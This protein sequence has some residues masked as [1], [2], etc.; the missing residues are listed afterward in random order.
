M[1]QVFENFAAMLRARLDARV[2][3]TEDSI[4]YT[5]YVAA[6]MYAGVRPTE[7]VLEYPHPTMAG[8]EIDTILFASGGRQS[9]AIEFKYDRAN[10]GGTNQNRTQRAAAVLI[11][12]FRLAKIPR[13]VAARRF[14]VYVTD[15]EMAG[16][17]R[18]P[19]NRLHTFFDIADPAGILLGPMAWSGF[20]QTFRTRVDP[21]VCDCRARPA[22]SA[23]LGDGIVLRAFEVLAA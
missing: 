4:R 21:H 8:T 13:N 7:V 1:E 18:N 15:R 10:P 14:F 2:F 9:A 11:D 23:E 5:F 20:S 22:F 17:F 12:V 16:Y 3:T 6:A 19:T